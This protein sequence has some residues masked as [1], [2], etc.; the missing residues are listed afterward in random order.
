MQNVKK[1]FTEGLI[2]FTIL[3]SLIGVR[4][5]VDSYLN[6]YYSPLLEIDVGSSSAYIQTPFHSLRDTLDGYSLHR[7]C[8]ELDYFFTSRRLLEE[9]RALGSPRFHTQLDAW[10]VH[11]VLDNSLAVDTSNT[12]IEVSPGLS[13]DSSDDASDT[14]HLPCNE[15]H[16]TSGSSPQSD[17]Q[18]S[19]TSAQQLCGSGP[20]GGTGA[21]NILNEEED[22]HNADVLSPDPLTQ[23]AHSST[24]EQ[25]SLL[26]G[27]ASL[28]DS[29]PDCPPSPSAIDIDQRWSHF[30]SLPVNDFDVLDP[31]V[32][33]RLSNLDSDISNAISQD[34][35]LRDAMVTGAD[36][37]NMVSPRSGARPVALQRES[38]LRLECTNSSHSDLP[39]RL[40]TGL[41]SLP[42][43]SVCNVTRNVTALD[44]LGDC[45]DEAVF[46]QINLLEMEGLD[47]MDEQLLGCLQSVNARVLE[48][49]D[50]DS[51]LSLESSSRS[52]DSPGTSEVSSSSSSSFCEDDCG[53]TGY[54][55][56]VDSLP[57]KGIVDYDTTWTPV[58]LTESIWHD[59]SYT[60]PAFFHQSSVATFSH[61]PIKEEPLS[62][63]EDS[64]ER[65]LSRDELRARAM[66]IPFS[67]PEIVNMPVEEFLEVLEG[68]SLSPSQ[69][70]LLRDIRRRGKN[71]LAAQN[72]RKRKLDAI[73]GLQEEV[74]RLQA[75]RDL[76]LRDKHHTAKA[77]VA[78]RHQI[79]Q[80]SRGVLAR[81]RDSSG[82][83]LTPERYTLQCGTNGRVMVQPIR[84]PAVSSSTGG[85]TEKRKKDKKQ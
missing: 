54:S 24:L 33:Q 6:G 74:E 48:D 5:D 83:P 49:L 12:S 59:H 9:V 65:E 29:V 62:E 84:R 67:A 47:T 44:A 72:C 75:R 50:S 77:T 80:L 23:L 79:E 45:L 27:S 2:Q 41:A 64:D 15:G 55:S 4:V 20:F 13:L 18:E 51:G 70:T 19:Q 22:D 16:L 38:L 58:D 11:Q 63:E 26:D 31:L 3:L 17:Q 60:S 8:P 25:E 56:E 21:C 52:P 14:E 61:K 10:L 7:K 30:L 68:R 46:T 28:S 57:P 82:Q 81:L 32:P 73:T 1:Y 66:C 34:V 37:Y 53:A 69:V 43:A 78:V 35:S 42:F 76:L 36:A 85:K 39:P 40:T 71:K